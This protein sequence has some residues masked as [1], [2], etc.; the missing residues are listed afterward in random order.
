MEQRSLKKQKSRTLSIQYLG[1]A[2]QSAC[3]AREAAPAGKDWQI[4]VNGSTTRH[5]PATRSTPQ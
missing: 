4:K 1:K 5:S 2:R 3:L